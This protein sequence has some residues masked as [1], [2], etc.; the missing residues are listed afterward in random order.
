MTKQEAMDFVLA[1][2]EDEGPESAEVCEDIFTA[3][4]GR[5]PDAEEG[6]YIW[7]LCCAALEGKDKPK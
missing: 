7:D 3:L 4:Y 5:R 2:G 6:A 1:C